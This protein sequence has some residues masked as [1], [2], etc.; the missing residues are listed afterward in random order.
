MKREREINKSIN[1]NKAVCLV[2]SFFLILHTFS[3]GD[4]Y[5][6]NNE[7][8][9]HRNGNSIPE[10]ERRYLWLGEAVASKV[11]EGKAKVGFP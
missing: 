8:H 11:P 9:I 2:K 6:L 7:V 4:V 3:D 1:Y 5:I 10:N